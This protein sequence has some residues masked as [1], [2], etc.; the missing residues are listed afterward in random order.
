M[1]VRH[2]IDHK[3]IVY[4]I[5]ILSDNSSSKVKYGMEEKAGQQDAKKMPDNRLLWFERC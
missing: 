1:F 5:D 4:P 2:W 3:T